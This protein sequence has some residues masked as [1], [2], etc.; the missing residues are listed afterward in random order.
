MAGLGSGSF[1]VIWAETESLV[2]SPQL[3]GETVLF[4][5]VPTQVPARKSRESESPSQWG[6]VGGAPARLWGVSL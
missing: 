6:G 5:K 4:W 2:S 3:Q 1:L